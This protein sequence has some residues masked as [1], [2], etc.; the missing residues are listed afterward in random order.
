MHY[1]TCYLQTDMIATH[2][3][4]TLMDLYNIIKPELNGNFLKIF[5]GPRAVIDIHHGT[6]QHI[7]DDVVSRRSDEVPFT[8]E[9]SFILIRKPWRFQLPDG[10]RVHLIRS[11]TG[12]DD[13][14]CKIIRWF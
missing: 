4:I 7:N 6:Y 12:V 9:I 3:F 14:F 1:F 11:V 2:F 10:A 5:F 13:S 8:V